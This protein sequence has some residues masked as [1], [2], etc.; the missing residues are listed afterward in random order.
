MLRMLLCLLAAAL[1]LASPLNA[2]ETPS[3][4]AA[5]AIEEADLFASGL[6]QID[7]ALGQAAEKGRFSSAIAVLSSVDGRVWT[8]GYGIVDA[9]DTRPPDPAE[10][11]YLI[12]SI[13]KTMT[14]VCVLQLYDRGAIESLDDPANR[15]L[16][17]VQIGAFEGQEVTIRQLLS[18]TSGLRTLG[19]GVISRQ[20]ETAPM[21]ASF[22]RRR[23]PG[24]IRRPGE[25]AV[26]SN[27]GFALL[28]TLIEDI[29]GDTLQDYMARELFA[30]L[31][32]GSAVLNYDI[33]PSMPYARALIIGER[34]AAPIPFDANTPFLA[35]AGSVM[36]SADDM[37]AYLAFVADAGKSWSSDVLSAPVFEEAFTAQ[38]QNHPLA[39]AV[40]LGFFMTDWDGARLIGHTGAFS[41]YTSYFSV[42]PETGLSAFIAAAGM[43][44]PSAGAAPFA[45]YGEG[46]GLINRAISGRPAERFTP[47]PIANAQVYSGTY[48]NDRRF[49]RGVAR[50]IGL[51]N[52][53]IV[54]ANSDGFLDIAGVSGFGHVGGGAIGVEGDGQTS[55]R[56]YGLPSSEEP[57]IT[58]NADRARK[59][60]WNERPSTLYTL[61]IGGGVLTFIGS[62]GGFAPVLPQPAGMGTFALGPVVGLMALGGIFAALLLF[63]A[64][65]HS[66]LGHLIAGET[67]RV[68]IINLCAWT[69]LLAS[70]AAACRLLFARLRPGADHKWLWNTLRMIAV[71]GL[72]G[73][74]VFV[75][76]TGLAD[77]RLV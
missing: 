67:F 42:S 48:I 29:T 33:A 54:A 56:L 20:Q 45:A 8:Q 3:P 35:P 30:P 49:S 4:P 77:P 31:G 36:A 23:T 7:A 38:A 70:A 71:S 5:P 69:V 32:M 75:V 13:T 9:E 46:A 50:L 37:A 44:A 58:M 21:A 34:G 17:R 16:T 27:V 39:N 62:F 65:G 18:H 25:A 43:P 52:P 64:P 28:G 51:Q 61:L 74:S 41:G 15:Y 72:A 24:L 1:L 40:G 76:I 22:I 12:A 53:V 68:R 6:G 73:L 19:F 55:A 59:A 2:Q 63:Y 60:N 66:I 14:A 10:T 47:A 11:R 57:Y 26:Y